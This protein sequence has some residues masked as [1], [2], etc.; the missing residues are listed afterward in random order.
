MSDFGL[1][2]TFEEIHDAL[3]RHYKDLPEIDDIK[4]AGD[5]SAQ[6]INVDPDFDYYLLLPDNKVIITFMQ[7]MPPITLFAYSKGVL[8]AALI[9]A[10]LPERKTIAS[11]PLPIEFPNITQLIPEEFW[12]SYSRIDEVHLEKKYVDQMIAVWDKLRNDRILLDLGLNDGGR[13]S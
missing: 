4:I 6:P 7:G 12:L 10:H 8:I 1:A 2:T 11:T 5:F 13:R 3:S 9:M